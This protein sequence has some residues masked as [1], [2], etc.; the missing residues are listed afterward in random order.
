MGAVGGRVAAREAG[1]ELHEAAMVGGDSYPHS[2]MLAIGSCH[3]SSD[4]PKAEVA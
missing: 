4:L 1:K 3:N 2:A